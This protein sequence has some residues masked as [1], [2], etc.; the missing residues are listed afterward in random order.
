[1]LHR[2]RWR[3]SGES[4]YHDIFADVAGGSHSWEDPPLGTLVIQVGGYLPDGEP[5][6]SEP[7]TFTFAPEPEEEEGL[8]V[9]QM[10]PAVPADTVRVRGLPPG[11]AIRVEEKDETEVG[12]VASLVIG[13][14]NR[15]VVVEVR[16][17][18]GDKVGH[19]RGR[20]GGDHVY[21]PP[22]EVPPPWADVGEWGRRRSRRWRPHTF[23]RR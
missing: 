17:P 3:F 1:M 12:G 11:H 9:Y 16:N 21:V 5:V 19:G 10:D 20:G 4:T 14:Q 22:G 13:G 2:G 6:W 18:Q 15:D 7:R 23:G 8:V